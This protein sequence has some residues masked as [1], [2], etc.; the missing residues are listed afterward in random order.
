MT[1]TLDPGLNVAVWSFS[2]AEKAARP[3]ISYAL[4]CGHRELNLSPC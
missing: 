4:T 3:R 1:S 2:G